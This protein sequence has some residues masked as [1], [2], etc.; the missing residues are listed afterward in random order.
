MDLVLFP[1]CLYAIALHASVD[2]LH[3]TL[4]DRAFLRQ[5]EDD[6]I[7]RQLRRPRQVTAVDVILPTP[8]AVARDDLLQ[9]SNDM[10]DGRFLLRRAHHFLS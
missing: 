5:R 9:P 7:D 6:D 4:G 8:A 10:G 1:Y 3:Q 2:H